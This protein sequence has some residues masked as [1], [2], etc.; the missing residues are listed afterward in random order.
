MEANEEP[1]SA[2]I[3]E[4]R[5][6]LGCD[7]E[8]LRALPAYDH[9]YTTLIIHMIPFLCR[10]APGSPAPHPHEHTALRWV[11][12]ADLRT[13]DLAPADVPLLADLTEELRRQPPA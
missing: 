7:L 8:L 11:A 1:A 6:E 3:R 5:E 2:L 10:L 13:I 9:D 12:P 4:I